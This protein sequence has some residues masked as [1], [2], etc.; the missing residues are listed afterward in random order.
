MLIGADVPDRGD[1]QL[2]QFAKGPVV[3]GIEP[4]EPGGPATLH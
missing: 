1:L 4:R 3:F 2:K